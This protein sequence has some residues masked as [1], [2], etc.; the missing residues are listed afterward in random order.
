M[1]AV[2]EVLSSPLE[3]RCTSVG[4]C[5]KER[6]KELKRTFKQFKDQENTM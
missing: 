4:N 1:A 3:E 2:D 5:S 6:C